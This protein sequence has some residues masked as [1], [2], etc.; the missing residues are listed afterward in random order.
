MGN[1]CPLPLVMDNSIISN[2]PD[3]TVRERGGSN[4]ELDKLYFSLFDPI[5]PTLTTC[6]FS[7]VISLI[8]LKCEKKML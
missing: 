4:V 7:T 1:G 3:H 5:G 8:Q 6:N 2:F